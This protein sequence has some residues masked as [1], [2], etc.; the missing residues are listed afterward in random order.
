[1]SMRR[2]LENH[3]HAL[4]EID[5]ILR[6]MKNIALMETQ[7]LARVLTTQRRVVDSIEA[8]VDDFVGFHP[9]VAGHLDAHTPLWVV[10]GS[11]RGFCGDFNE[12][13]RATVEQRLCEPSLSDASLVVVGR[14]LSSKFAKDQRVAVCVAGPTVVE[15]VPLVMV[16]LMEQLRDM[17]ERQGPGKRFAL[18]IVHQRPSSDGGEIR[19][20]QP[21]K[22]NA[23]RPT[24]FGYPPLLNLM[25][26]AFATHLLDE[27]LFSLL[28][29]VFY[30]SLMAENQRR[31]QHM[32]EAI[33]RLE[34]DMAE[35]LQKRNMSR[36][37][38]ITEE[39]EVIMLSA[40]ML[41]RSYN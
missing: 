40:E 36:Q 9:Q 10:I 30:S 25:P 26:L 22:N 33:Q 12:R 16:N 2:E 28:H 8:A 27:H 31:F 38:E 4:G 17:Q 19:I 35:L 13:L 6:A 14:K 11:E 34:R 3:L 20:H 1:M 23:S 41:K 5:G 21:M 32:D 37:E 7:K 15:E 24:R 18:T 29:E 39:I